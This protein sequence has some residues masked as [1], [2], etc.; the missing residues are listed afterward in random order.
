MDHF[1]V[2]YW[3]LSP[4]IYLILYHIFTYDQFLLFGIIF[5]IVRIFYNGSEKRKRGERR[6]KRNLYT[7]KADS[8][9]ENS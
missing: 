4:P 1:T 7:W 3:K 6:K 8:T 5:I 2:A 9:A